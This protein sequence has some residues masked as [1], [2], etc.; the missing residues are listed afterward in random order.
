M[1][2]TQGLLLYCRPGFEK[3]TAAEIQA[4]ASLHGLSGFARARPDTGFVV[5]ELYPPFDAA[6]AAAIRFDDLVFARHLLQLFRCEPWK[7][8]ADDRITPLLAQLRATGTRFA[9]LRLE[10]ADTNA[11]KELAGF[12]KKFGPALE[13]ALRKGQVLD[14]RAQET[15]HLFFLDSTTVLAGASTPANA[16][17]WL[18]GIPRLRFPAAAPSRSTLKLE[19]ALLHFLSAEERQEYL[20]EGR[21]AV[22]LGAAPGGWTWQLVRHG[23]S[24]TAIDNGAMDPALMRSGLVEHLRSDGF[25]YRPPRP[26]TWLVCDMVEQPLRV[27]ELCARWI[28]N[29]DAERAMFN[30]KLPMKKRYEELQQCRRAIALAMGNKPSNLRLKQLYHDREEVTAYLTAGGRR[31]TG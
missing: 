9:E 22:D 29:G 31:R 20:R 2:D 30:L 18:M 26:V 24:V 23:L 8:P 25:R 12:L 10:T 11:A 13:S 7:L 17:P 27:A 16:S 5:F 6:Q 19:E 3:E 1:T 21:T 4:V 15:L 14:R 28:A